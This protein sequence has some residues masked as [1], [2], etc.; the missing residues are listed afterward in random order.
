MGELGGEG[1]GVDQLQV[2][3]LTSL[4]S[5]VNFSLE[6]MLCRVDSWRESFLLQR[7]G[8]LLLNTLNLV[9][10]PQNFH[11]NLLLFLLSAGVFSLLLLTFIFGRGF[12]D[13]VLFW[14]RGG[15]GNLLVGDDVE[16]DGR[17]V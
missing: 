14:V 6:A 2:E 7:R 10:L 17:F 3:V 1:V 11:F 15:M 16:V 8:H 12:E 13:E 9:F 4:R 5:D